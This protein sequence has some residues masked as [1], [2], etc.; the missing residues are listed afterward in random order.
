[1]SKVIIDPITE[2]VIYDIKKLCKIKWKAMQ[3]YRKARTK[4]RSS[5]D[6][7]QYGIRLD[8]KT[9]FI[10]NQV[11]EPP[12]Y[13][14]RLKDD[15]RDEY[16]DEVHQERFI[17][18]GY[19]TEVQD[20][21]NEI[22]AENIQ[23][24]EKNEMKQIKQKKGDLVRQHPILIISIIIAGCI[25]GFPFFMDH[26]II[27]NQSPSTIPNSLWVSFLGSYTG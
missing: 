17:D 12:E 18:E 23:I 26:Y 24:E 14:E 25:I 3:R 4:Y 5:K 6:L 2:P 7:E 1:M 20:E 11:E 13:I 15:Y 8:C 19:K 9:G 22:F 21:P 10:Y 16:L 27:G